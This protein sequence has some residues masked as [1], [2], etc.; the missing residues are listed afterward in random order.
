MDNGPCS[1]PNLNY[2]LKYTNGVGL[3]PWGDRK[4]NSAKDIHW[5]VEI[6]KSW[7][8]EYVRPILVY[9]MLSCQNCEFSQGAQCENVKHKRSHFRKKQW[10]RRKINIKLIKFQ[11]RHTVVTSEALHGRSVNTCRG[12]LPAMWRPRVKRATLIDK[13]GTVIKQWVIARPL[14]H[15]AGSGRIT[16]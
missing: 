7:I 4:Q 8:K 11:W 1:L 14:R 16:A 5:I 3:H 9:I 2:T 6:E 13:S 10:G 12:S 15:K